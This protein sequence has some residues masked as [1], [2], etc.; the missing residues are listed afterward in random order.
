[1]LNDRSALNVAVPAMK[2]PLCVESSPSSASSDE[3][4]ILPRH[5][6][7]IVTG[8]NRTKRAL[9]GQTAVV[10]KAVGL[11]GWHFLVRPEFDQPWPSELHG[12]CT[13]FHAFLLPDTVEN[14]LI[15]C[16]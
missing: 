10:K 12:S 7:V 14:I 15:L 4:A 9:V 3:V 1:M 2:V 11:G 8:N 6:K 16:E 13:C 5:T